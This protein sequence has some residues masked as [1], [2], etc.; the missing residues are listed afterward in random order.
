M[1]Q[2]A[3]RTRKIFYVSLGIH[4]VLLFVP[5]LV[6]ALMSLFEPDPPE[7]LTVNLVDDPSTGPVVAA[8]TTRLPPS[9]KPEA[10]VNPPPIPPKP[11]PPE[12]ELPDVPPVP[13]PPEPELAD[14]PAPPVPPRV[15][16]PP[17]PEL[18]LPKVVKKPPKKRPVVPPDTDRTLRNTRKVG[19]R[20]GSQ[21]NKDI[22]IGKRD[23]AQRYGEKFSNTPNGGRRNEARYA[24]LLGA[25]L[26]VRWSAFV[27]ARAQLGDEKPEVVVLIAISGDGRLLEARI[28]KPSGNAAMNN[29][30][31]R[32]LETLKTQQLPRSPDGR[33][34]RNRVIFDTSG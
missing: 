28:E 12:P 27:P 9:P 23:A 21:T 33:V 6:M 24:A 13:A 22:A 29:A 16:A 15:K 11:A 20:T 18:D 31:N 14:L 5:L 10:E 4:I 30:V 3:E 1:L 17:E 25:F 8:E 7:D 19:V 34:W 32:L 2:P 26:K